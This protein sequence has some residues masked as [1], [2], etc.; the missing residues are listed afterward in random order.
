MKIQYLGTAAAEGWPAVFCQCDPCRRAKAKGGKN[1]RTRSSVLINEKYLV[2]FPP[3]TYLHALRDGIELADIEH[4][5]IT[6]SHEDHFY[7]Q[8]LC[9]RSEPYAHLKEERKL[10]LWG[11]EVVTGMIDHGMVGLDFGA[12]STNTV[13]RGDTFQAGE[14]TVTAL[15]ANHMEP[16]KALLYCISDGEKGI[17]YAHDSGWYPEET[18]QALAGRNLDLVNFDCTFGPK[19][20]RYGHMGIPEVLEAREKLWEIGAIGP[21]AKC[22]ITHF[23]H[24]SGLLH[25][26]LEEHVAGTG[27]IVAY[28]GMVMEL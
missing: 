7:P 10:E 9:L 23:S 4:L 15:A 25:Q 2:D 21:E 18:W 19:S 12:I 28:D 13:K 22:V 16:E 27:L 11:N 26:E 8:D 17:F 24:N 5:F 6:H 1:I 20:N 3:D 14:L